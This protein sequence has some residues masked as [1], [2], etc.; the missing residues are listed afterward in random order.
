MLFGG[1]RSVEAADMLRVTVSTVKLDSAV[2]VRAG[3]RAD[4]RRGATESQG[5]NPGGGVE[6]RQ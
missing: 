1:V 2:L 4:T 6:R 5:S 3:W